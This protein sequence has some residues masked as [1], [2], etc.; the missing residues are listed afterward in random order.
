MPQN[1]KR[2]TSCRMKWAYLLSRCGRFWPMIL[3][4]LLDPKRA[5]R[6]EHNLDDIRVFQG[7][8]EERPAG[9]AQA[10]QQTWIVTRAYQHQRSP[11]MTNTATLSRA[12]TPTMAASQAVLF[13][14]A[15]SRTA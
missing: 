12:D 4:I 15:W 5:V 14:N 10:F 6:V 3:A 8:H 2:K 11:P 9:M 13:L 7:I 1:L